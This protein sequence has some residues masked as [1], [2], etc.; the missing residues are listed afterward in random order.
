MASLLNLNLDMILDD[1]RLT[2]VQRIRPSLE[3][4]SVE[5]DSVMT[6]ILTAFAK[7]EQEITA[8]MNRKNT[9]KITLKMNS[10]DEKRD[11]AVDIIGEAI[12]YYR[13]KRNITLAEAAELLAAPFANAFAGISLTNNTLQTNRITLFL[14]DTQSPEI[15]EAITTLRLNEEFTTLAESNGAYEVL[16]Q[17]RADFKEGD[18]TPLLQPSRRSMNRTLA[19]LEQ[20]LEF[21]ISCGSE[22]HEQIASEI[23]VPIT[24]IMSVA[25]ARSTRKENQNN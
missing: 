23:A 1:E 3:S 8:A 19:F 20:Y 21:K 25:R 14:N 24:E 17:E 6:D 16:R 2:M 12:E 5:E 7:S 15:Q 9:K 13:K 22:K 10:E 11:D 18:A 4:I